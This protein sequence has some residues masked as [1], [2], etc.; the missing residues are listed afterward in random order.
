MEAF[1]RLV[2]GMV[3]YIARERATAD[4]REDVRSQRYV[5][6]RRIDDARITAREAAVYAH[7]EK[8]NALLE[9]LLEQTSSI[10]IQ[11]GER[12]ASVWTMANN[13]QFETDERERVKRE[14]E[15]REKL[16]DAVVQSAVIAVPVLLARKFPDLQGMISQLS[17]LLEAYNKSTDTSAPNPV[18]S[19]TAVKAKANG[20]SKTSGANGANGH[21]SRPSDV[22]PSVQA[23]A[24]D[25][26]FK[27]SPFSQQ[28]GP[29]VM[30]EPTIEPSKLSAAGVD[31]ESGSAEETSSEESEA[32]SAS[33]ASSPVIDDATRLVVSQLIQRTAREAYDF[34]SLLGRDEKL[35]V[36]RSLIDPAIVPHWN[37]WITSL[38]RY[39]ANPNSDE[40]VS[41]L[42]DL[43]FVLAAYLEQDKTV[44][45]K[46]S[47]EIGPE[48]IQLFLKLA[49]SLSELSALI[50][51]VRSGATSPSPDEPNELVDASR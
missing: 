1:P 47:V 14:R 13:L 34:A 21:S 43:S 20:K 4:A 22:E 11:R 6:Q 28:S 41:P 51:S 40:T 29:V 31:E 48:A 12:E 23:R 15:N 26:P 3:D 37:S 44:L 32:S 25:P 16:V 18:V 45:M 19:V 46:L 33:S 50:T 42:V 36:V 30:V 35:D 39:E 2:S 10:A 24:V 49:G 17:G 7:L 5:E 9:R 8:G 27:V 38:G